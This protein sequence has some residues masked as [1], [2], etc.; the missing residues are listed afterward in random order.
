MPVITI[1]R[2]AGSLGDSIAREV[3]KQLDYQLVTGETIHQMGLACDQDF[4]KACAAFANEA[5]KGFWERFFFGTPTH[6]VLFESLNL[7][8]AAQGNVVIVGRGAQMALAGLPGVFS[9]RILAPFETRVKRVMELRNLTREAAEEFVIWHGHQRR[10]LVE[11][12]YHHDL[13]DWQLYDLVLNTQ[14]YDLRGGTEIILRAVQEKIRVLDLPALKA[15]VARKALAKKVEFQLLKHLNASLVH[16]IQVESVGDGKVTLRGFLVSEE[17][18]ARASQIASAVPG[19]KE[20]E[21][22]VVVIHQIDY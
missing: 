20:V 6:T 2:Q 14:D 22:L 15:A 16:G 10:K 13:D 5:Q 11:S 21:N 3:A 19:V 9:A 17:D 8:L 4:K 12:V 7:D 18:K 1:S